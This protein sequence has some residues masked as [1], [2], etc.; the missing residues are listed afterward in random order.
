MKILVYTKSLFI[1]DE[2]NKNLFLFENIIH[3]DNLNNQ[4]IDLKNISLIIHNISDFPEDNIYILNLIKE[5]NPNIKLL[6]LTNT[7][8]EIEGL[9][10]LKIGYK[11][12]LHSYS[13]IDILKTAI[14][15]ILNGNIYVYPTLMQFLIAQISIT[16]TTNNDK[17]LLNKLTKKELEVLEFLSKGLSNSKIANELNIAE[18][19]VKKHIGSMF[20]KLKVKDRI[21]LALFF[22]K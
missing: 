9:G 16:Q 3:L 19:T 20:E 13:G 6:A 22:K 2:I 4:N 15:S 12:Y 11:G 21:S 1:F 8:D 5:N 10:Y 7:P 17:K 14:D 18:I